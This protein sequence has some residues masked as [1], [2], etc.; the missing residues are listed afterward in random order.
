MRLRVGV[1]VCVGLAVVMVLVEV[2]VEDSSL[3]G[4]CAHVTPFPGI[5]SSDR[6]WCHVAVEAT[7]YAYHLISST[8]FLVGYGGSIV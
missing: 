5:P 8:G 2:M 3:T 1:C 4:C 7:S 6:V